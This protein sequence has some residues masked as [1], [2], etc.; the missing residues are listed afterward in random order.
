MKLALR[1]PSRKFDLPE[2]VETMAKWLHELDA[3]AL[4]ITL[5]I[6]RHDHR[7]RPVN[8]QVVNSAARHFINALNQACFGRHRARRGFTVGFAAAY[9][10]GIYENHPHI[11]LSV[12]VPKHIAIEEFCNLIDGVSNAVHWIDEH[13]KLERYRDMGWMRY[14]VHHGADQ[15]LVELVRPSHPA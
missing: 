12:T 13:R 3:W 14:L 7:G 6:K 2:V 15:V 9:G 1:A 8:Q 11:H 5:T 4:A 10:W